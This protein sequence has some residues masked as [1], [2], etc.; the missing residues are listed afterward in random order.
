MLIICFVVY[1]IVGKL[2]CSNGTTAQLIDFLVQNN[3]HS[4]ISRDHF[5]SYTVTLL[6]QIMV[7]IFIFDVVIKTCIKSLELPCILIS[8]IFSV[9]L[10]SLNGWLSL[11]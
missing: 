8:M 4:H 5:A 11:Y 2:S 9:Y 1:G 10:T 7:Q 3:L 6:S